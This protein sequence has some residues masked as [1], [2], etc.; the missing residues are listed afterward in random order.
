MD[1]P[2]QELDAMDRETLLTRARAMR[3]T[4]QAH[5]DCSMHDLGWHQP[6]LCNLLPDSLRKPP[7]VPEWPQFMRGCTRYRQSLDR[8][9]PDAPRSDREYAE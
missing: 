5:R 9:L 6:D 4:I 1:D 2:D 7:T 8:Q 3:R